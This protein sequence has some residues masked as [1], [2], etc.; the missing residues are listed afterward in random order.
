MFSTHAD[1]RSSTRVMV[2]SP[3]ERNDVV[4]GTATSARVVAAA[5]V[6]PV[7]ALREHFMAG[8]PARD[9]ITGLNDRPQV[10]AY[11]KL[12]FT[13]ANYEPEGDIRP[14]SGIEDMK[15]TVRFAEV[16][17]KNDTPGFL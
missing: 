8:L 16:S 14:C 5:G 13:T 1:A 9:P 10:L 12:V 6:P 11:Y 17:D 3:S 2:S 4:G 7:Q 15:A